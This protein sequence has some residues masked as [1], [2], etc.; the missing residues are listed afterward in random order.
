[1]SVDMTRTIVQTRKTT[2]GTSHASLKNTE[3]NTSEVYGLIF[4]S[5]L[6][7]CHS[8]ICK[9]KFGQTKFN[10]QYT[11]TS[12]FHSSQ[13]VFASRQIEGDKMLLMRG[14]ALA[15]RKLENHLVSRQLPQ[16]SAP[17]CSSTYNLLSTNAMR[18][19]AKRGSG[20]Y[21]M[22]NHIWQKNDIKDKDALTNKMGGANV[23]LNS[24]LTQKQIK[25]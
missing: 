3:V 8:S 5:T 11:Q 10:Y 22:A 9:Y 20:V 21:D 13:F 24:S 2:T 17:V 4:L 19:F 1:M 15:T 23:I 25:S 7:W 16:G 18:Q 6:L 14:L 12:T